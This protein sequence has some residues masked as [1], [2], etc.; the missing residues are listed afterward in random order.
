MVGP[1]CHHLGHVRYRFSMGM[2]RLI[3]VRL[4]EWMCCLRYSLFTLPTRTRQNWFALSGPCR[5]CEHNWRQDKTV[6][7]C[8][9]P[10][11]ILQPFSLKYID[12]YWKLGNWKLGRDKTKLCCLVSNCV[13]TADADRTRQSVSAVWTAIRDKLFIKRR[14]R[15][16]YRRLVISTKQHHWSY[17]LK[18]LPVYILADIRH[19]SFWLNYTK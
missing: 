14:T 16:I 8:F 1:H 2:R 17:P 19:L 7:S 4:I 5:R 9:I 10:I 15:P 6:F 3:C 11:S 12:D 18:V 13:H